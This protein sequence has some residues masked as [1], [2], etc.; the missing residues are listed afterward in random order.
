MSDQENPPPGDEPT[1]AYYNPYDDATRLERPVPAYDPEREGETAP[2]GEN[3]P[4]AGQSRGSL[5]APMITVALLSLIIG[6][7]IGYLL[8]HNM[9][10]SNTTTTTTTSSTTT[11]MPTT[12]TTVATTT[13]TSRATTTTVHHSTT[14][15]EKVTTTTAKA[16]TTTTSHTTPT[17]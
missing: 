5:V 1:R 12:T 8:F 11:T 13:T 15:S 3:D 14:T 16:T 6:I 2:Y 10:T 17:T 9:N 4:K 7:G